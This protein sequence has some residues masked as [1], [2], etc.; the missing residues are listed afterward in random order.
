MH[1]TARRGHIAGEALVVFH[2]T[3][4]Q[5]INVL[6]LKLGKQIGWVFTQGVD[7][8]VQTATVRHRNDDFLNTLR[9]AVLDQRVHCGNKALPAFKRE[10]F[11]TD[12]A[13]MQI[14]FQTFGFGQLQQNAAFLIHAE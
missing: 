7:Q 5:I 1:R 11:L 12:V 10:T 4:W 2:V 9:A 13:G 6:T 8:Y 14:A 3:G